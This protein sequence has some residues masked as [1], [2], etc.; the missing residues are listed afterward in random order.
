M[1]VDKKPI[2]FCFL[3]LW[4]SFSS[5]RAKG[6]INNIDERSNFQIFF[7]AVAYKEPTTHTV[8]TELLLQFPFTPR[9]ER[10]T[11]TYV[12]MHIH[13]QLQKTAKLHT[14]NW[15]NNTICSIDMLKT[16]RTIIRNFSNMSYM[17]RKSYTHSFPFQPYGLAHA[18]RDH[19]NGQ[20][21]NN[22]KS[23]LFTLYIAFLIT[24]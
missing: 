18:V 1:M 7:W 5:N 24:R 9:L 21:Y 4:V 16:K 3:Y 14:L 13:L 11:M 23:I 2:Y 6:T 17:K 10:S 8:H 20:L 19:T 15:F 12:I 22:C